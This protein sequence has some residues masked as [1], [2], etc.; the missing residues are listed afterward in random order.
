MAFLC[1]LFMFLRIFCVLIF[2]RGKKVLVL[3]LG[4]FCLDSSLRPIF[5]FS[6]FLI[7]P[8]TYLM[9][10]RIN[11]WRSFFTWCARDTGTPP[12]PDKHTVP[13]PGGEINTKTQ[14]HKD[15]KT[16][17]HIDTKTIRQKTIRQDRT[18]KH[19]SKKSLGFEKHFL[20]CSFPLPTLLKNRNTNTNKWKQRSF[21][22][23]RF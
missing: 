18:R 12:P 4:F 2:P 15:T 16:K 1:Y 3:N 21:L 7:L 17:R 13:M 9:R 14:I 19:M 23:S 22:Q 8:V 20:S 6:T 11:G 5:P 10:R